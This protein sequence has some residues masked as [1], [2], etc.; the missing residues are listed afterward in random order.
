MY[1]RLD[2]LDLHAAARQPGEFVAFGA[3]A[4]CI[5]TVACINFTNLATA[6]AVQRAREVGVR[7]SLGAARRQLVGQFLG[8]AIAY[9][10]IAMLLAAALVELLLPP[11]NAFAGTALTFDYWGD[12]RIAAGLVAFA[13][14]SV[15]WRAPIPRS[16]CRPSSPRRC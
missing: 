13:P 4:I 2:R 1:R 9:A 16:I 12:G 3:I 10:A 5:L 6:R 7:K 11:F 15:C 14:S 8:E